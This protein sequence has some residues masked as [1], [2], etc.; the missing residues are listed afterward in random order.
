M[1]G[2]VVVAVGIAVVLVIAALAVYLVYFAPPATAGPCGTFVAP[3]V[4]P[5]DT[6]VVYTYSS[7]LGGPGANGS[8]AAGVFDNFSRDY[9]VAVDVYCP[10]GDLVNA[11]QHPPTKANPDVVVGLD[12]ISAPKAESLNLLLPYASPD[13]ANVPA[14]LVANL[15]P[16]HYV[17]PYEYG[18][19]AIDYT[20][21]FY[22]TTDGGIANSSF[23][24]FVANRTWASQMAYEDP[25][26]DITGEEFLAWE[27]LY[28][29]AVLHESDWQSFW[30][31]LSSAGAVVAPDWS[32]A[33]YNDFASRSAMVVSYTTDPASAA[34]YGGGPS[35]NATVTTHHGARYGWETLYGLGIVQG[36]SNV[37]L[38]KAFV[39]YFLSGNVQSQLPLNEWE[40]PANSTVA[41]PPVYGSSGLIPPSSIVPL[42]QFTTPSELAEQFSLANANGWLSQW[43]D[44]VGA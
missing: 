34:Y 4:S 26:T 6:L 18:F 17:T 37:T 20:T 14:A 35:F 22:N 30:T 2:R 32:T 41:L 29:T 15:S 16:G 43:E 31:T 24:D 36:A 39:N 12:E 21:A 13:L 25:T 28:Y 44:L 11:I 27:V 3:G 8:A 19:L 23:P 10:P 7:L 38:A 33:F 42:N 5:H 1:L 40:Y 9:G